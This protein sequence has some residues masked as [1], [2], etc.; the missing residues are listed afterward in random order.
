VQV[1]AKVSLI[2]LGALQIFSFEKT[3]ADAKHL[4]LPVF[5]VWD[6]DHESERVKFA[7]RIC[8]DSDPKRV[9]A[10]AG[11]SLMPEYPDYSVRGRCSP[12]R[13][14]DAQPISWERRCDVSPGG[15]WTCEKHEVLFAR[16][17]DVPVR[18]TTEPPSAV[19][20]T[21]KEV[22]L[23]EGW[24]ALHYILLTQ[25]LQEVSISDWSDFVAQIICRSDQPCRECQAGSVQG[26]VF[27]DCDT[28]Y[29][30]VRSDSRG[31]LGLVDPFPGAE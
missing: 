10:F 30:R 5:E 3:Y 27:I 8:S 19:R 7:E 31:R 28:D 23:E 13:M 14:F 4:P 1:N 11:T 26:D 21:A 24:R 17:G 9:E 16:V 20:M 15:E 25:K 22:S 12:H 6:V 18:L 29:F 2:L